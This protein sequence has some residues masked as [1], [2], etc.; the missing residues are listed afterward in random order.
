MAI[1]FA[2]LEYV[3]RSSGGNACLKAAY[4]GRSAIACERSGQRFFFQHR[5]GNVHHE[6]LLPE[7]VNQ[8]FKESSV[9]WNAAEF[10]EKRKNSQLGKDMVLA[11]P[12]DVQITLEDKIEITQQFA[13]QYFVEKGLAVQIDVHAPHEGERNWHAHLLITTR[14]FTEDGQALGK[15]ARDL[16]PEVRFGKVVES[17][18]WG[19]AWRDFQN[20][21]F[22]EK[23][24]DL[25]VDPTAVIGQEHLGPVRMRRFTGDSEIALRADLIRQT[26]EQVAQE[27]EAILRLIT[28]HKAT[29]TIK[30]IDAFLGKH[31]EED[32]RSTIRKEVLHS[33]HL[34]ALV[35]REEKKL[36]ERQASPEPFTTTWVREEEERIQRFADRICLKNSCRVFQRTAKTVSK[37]YTFSE[38]QRAC[39]TGAV[40]RH[41]ET[42]QDGLVIIQGR[43]G[44]GKSYTLKAIQEAYRKDGHTVVG[45][46]PTHVVVQDLKD[47]AGFE[48]AKTVHKMLFDHKNNRDVIERN[49]VLVVDEAGMIGNEAFTELLHVALRTKSKV[50]LVG[51]DRQLS[52]V[53]RGGMF[54]YLAHR[55][56]SYTLSQVR[57]Q[58]LSWQKDVSIRLSQGDVKG[59]LYQLEG[60]RRIHWHEIESQAM[61]AVVDQWTIQ[62]RLQSD[63]Q[64][65][66]ITH[67]NAKVEQFN[68]AIHEYRHQEG[69]LGD[70]EYECLTQRGKT[71]S[72]IHVSV[73]DR[74][75]LTLTD[76][77]LGLANGMVG[78]LT[79]VKEQ[80]KA[81][82]FVMKQDNGQ[83]VSFNPETFHGFTLGYA[84]TV[85]K[86]QGK[87]LPT[88]LVYHDGQGS[89]PLSYVG[90]TRHEQDV[91]LF[92]AK[93]K[94]ADFT[95]LV[96]QMGREEG[97]QASLFYTT[98]QEQAKE[99]ERQERE[100]AL[101]Q[102]RQHQGKWDY[103]VK[104]ILKNNLVSLAEHLVTRVRDYYH[105]N[106]AF[107]TPS[108]EKVTPIKDQSQVVK[109]AVEKT[110]QREAQHDLT[111][112]GPV[113]PPKKSYG[114]QYESKVCAYSR[115]IPDSIKQQEN[116]GQ[117]LKEF[118][119]EQVP[120]FM[121]RYQL[122]NPSAIREESF[123]RRVVETY[124]L[125]SQKQS[126]PTDRLNDELLGR[127][128]YMHKHIFDTAQQM[129]LPPSS[130][131][132]PQEEWRLINTVWR[133]SKIWYDETKHGLEQASGRQSHHCQK[134]IEMEMKQHQHSLHK[135]EHKSQDLHLSNFSKSLHDL[136]FRQSF[137]EHQL[138]RFDRQRYH[139]QQEQ[140]KQQQI[141]KEI[142]HQFTRGFER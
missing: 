77:E 129:K 90:L 96:R 120:L 56:G 22:R 39:F 98:P 106:E 136:L 116:P 62:Q 88:V 111:C 35:S 26:N 44:T 12:D 47:K 97:K 2:R 69:Q 105:S 140:Q 102:E 36:F 72:R 104:H 125:I 57:R 37:A 50:I 79:E 117:A 127:C 11:L 24:Y 135:Q 75:Q 81:Y 18:V 131:T 134:A 27:P 66:I 89:K 33:P 108:E 41:K 53:A 4:N 130:R 23:G 103:F 59:A 25:T 43:A 78:T 7:G 6:V 34:I 91:H 142:V 123:T 80:D 17:E 52:S 128:A 100:R 118:L 138:E 112:Q 48:K 87:T 83:E 58:E 61:A 21:Y 70:S 113:Q 92:I 38:E 20:A 119:G 121:K 76:K 29:F 85:Y 8:R 63:K 67:T 9:L 124:Q 139:Q 54:G 5:D 49:S 137:R 60:H 19:E 42:E 74:L 82:T 132:T 32:K 40:G 51:D 65:L 1:A 46:A 99:R 86:A 115:K 101:N 73:G 64:C 71:W 15:K 16:D 84:S 45:L 68:K 133:E 126:L 28:R 141:Q 110:E 122:E 95:D 107:Y 93:E 94:T 114:Q 31:V 13:Q 30:D 55:Y 14:R 10:A 109:K 3:S